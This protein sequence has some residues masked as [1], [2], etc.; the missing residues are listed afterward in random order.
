[1]IASGGSAGGTLSL[2]VARNVGPDA[3]DDD[4]KVSTRPCALVLYN[5]AIGESVLE[6]IGQ[7]GPAQAPVNAQ[8]VALNRPRKDEPPVIM[9]FGTEDRPFL[10]RAGE[11]NRQALAQGNRCEL[12]TADK[13]AHSFFN[14]QP[15]R[16]ATARKADEFLVSLG[17]LKGSPT[18]AENPAAPLVLVGKE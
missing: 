15:W 9:F 4:L 11:F 18:I 1:V 17:Y 5:P 12:W 7:G 16:S 14:N 3:K 2:L 13:M 6:R 8:I 10:D